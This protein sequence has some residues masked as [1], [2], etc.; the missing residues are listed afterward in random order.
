MP[1]DLAAAFGL[2]GKHDA[3]A[4]GVYARV[5][6]AS[7]SATFSYLEL[8]TAVQKLIARGMSEHDAFTSVF[9]TAETLGRDRH[10]ML[11]SA[12]G[13]LDV[14][15]REHEAIERAMQVRLTEGMERERRAIDAVLAKQAEIQK[16]IAELDAQLGEAETEEQRLRA[17]LAETEQRVATQGERLKA[18]YEQLKREMSADLATMRAA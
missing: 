10:A 6:E 18:V 2:S 1:R 3:D 11:E 13:H 4:V 14:L 8:R 15:E 7:D 16:R 17:Q 5:L 9:V 12:Q